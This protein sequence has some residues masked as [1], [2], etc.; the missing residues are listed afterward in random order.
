MRTSSTVLAATTALVAACGG[1]GS[2]TSGDASA[3]DSA[4]D[5][6]PCATTSQSDLPGVH[7]EIDPSR[8]VFSLAQAHAGIAI[9]Y[10]VIVDANVPGVV[11][12]SQDAGNCGAADGSGLIPFESVAGAGQHYCVCDTGLCPPP[13]GAPVTLPA[14][15]YHHTFMWDG[16]NWSGPSDT[17][18]PEGP[19]FPA[20]TYTLTVSAVGTTP[21]DG[22]A[23]SFTVA[24]T[25]AIT[26]TP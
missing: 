25:L 6:P 7:I 1:I 16:T 12:R 3:G 14:G 20:G 19:P 13:T 23:S 26:L 8:C 11:P 10:D 15:R 5:A 17:G 24:G 18:N 21:A 4:P 2:T 22:S 9:G